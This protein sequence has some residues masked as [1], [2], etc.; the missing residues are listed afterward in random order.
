MRQVSLT[1]LRSML[2]QQVQEVFLKCVTITHPDLAQ[3]LRYV[4]D[5]VSLTRSD[6][7]YE[8]ASFRMALPDDEEEN[9]GVVQMT[10]PIID[11]TIV[12]AI[13]STNDPFTVTLI[14]IR[15]S[16][17][18]TVEVGPFVFEALTVDFDRQSATISLGFNRNIFEDAYPKDIFAP[19]NDPPLDFVTP[20]SPP[21]GVILFPLD[22]TGDYVSY[23]TL[24]NNYV[25]SAPIEPPL[26]APIIP[27][28][29]PQP[30][31]GAHLSSIIPGVI[32]DIYIG[33]VWP[34][35]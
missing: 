13:R 17:P 10:I 26:A 2:A 33:S 5:R 7:T 24:S 4:N 30:P 1:A 22:L 32:D 31:G 18:E 3:P 20:P 11:Y 9:I 15:A 27:P 16:A 6:G 28:E 35:G 19:S 14:I 23:Y 12:Q 34:G 25:L 21:E 29:P 8:A